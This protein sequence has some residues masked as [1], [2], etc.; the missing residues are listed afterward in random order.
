MSRMVILSGTGPKKGKEKQK[1]DSCLQPVQKKHFLCEW[2][3]T[4]RSDREINHV[5]LS[6]HLNAQYCILQLCHVQYAA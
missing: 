1:Q 4:F 5:L 2:K 6:V 3:S